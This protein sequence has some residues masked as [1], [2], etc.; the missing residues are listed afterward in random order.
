MQGT[1][2]KQ[3]L[4]VEPSASSSQVD[5]ITETLTALHRNG[6]SQTFQLKPHMY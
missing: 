2:Q 3:Q 6:P 5:K 1:E 4:V